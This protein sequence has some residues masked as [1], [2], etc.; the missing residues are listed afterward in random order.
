MD[1]T[2]AALPQIWPLGVVRLTHA[3]F[4]LA[5]EGK[6]EGRPD[7]KEKQRRALGSVYNKR[8][9]KDYDTISCTPDP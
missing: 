3:E 6:P 9:D 1:N 7:T 5:R 4:Y 2:T 8:E